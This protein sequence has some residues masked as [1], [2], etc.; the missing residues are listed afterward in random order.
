MLFE[1]DYAEI[2]ASILYQC[3]S[4]SSFGAHVCHRRPVE[5]HRHQRFCIALFGPKWEQ[6]EVGALLSEYMFD[7]H[8][9]FQKEPF[10][11]VRNFMLTT[12]VLSAL[13][14]AL[15][16]ILPTQ[17]DCHGDFMRVVSLGS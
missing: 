4:E 8:M 6:S 5:L 16:E 13:L 14:A 7:W 2:Y 15:P 17:I 11:E 9:H 12:G 1:A 3:L 10:S